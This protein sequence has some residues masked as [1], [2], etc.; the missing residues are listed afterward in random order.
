MS[1]LYLPL[2]DISTTDIEKLAKPKVKPKHFSNRKSKRHF[3][4]NVHFLR[5]L[6]KLFIPT[7]ILLFIVLPIKLR[8]TAINT[9][10]TANAN[11]KLKL[12]TLDTNIK[13]LSS[14]ISELT[15]EF[16]SLEMS[17]EDLLLRH[18]ESMRAYDNASF[19][20]KELEAYK[21]TLNNQLTGLI[22]QSQ[23]LQMQM[24]SRYNDYGVKQYD[25]YGYPISYWNPNLNV[26]IPYSYQF[27]P[28][29]QYN[30]YSL[31]NQYGFLGKIRLNEDP[32]T[33]YRFPVS[34]YN[35]YNDYTNKY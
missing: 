9:I 3:L 35:S 20:I 10:T 34:K 19:A 14:S 30:P 17:K 25:M 33:H 15:A 31:P 21:A 5:F 6:L 26:N 18:S 32:F 28:I 29:Q 16:Q 22:S 8:I 1:S 27:N 2:T 12:A 7:I 24:G 13:Q 23:S 4:R 11:S